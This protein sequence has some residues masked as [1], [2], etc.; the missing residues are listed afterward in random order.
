MDSKQLQTLGLQRPRPATYSEVYDLVNRQLLIGK[1][2]VASLK[3][4]V[5]HSELLKQAQ[6]FTINVSKEKIKLI[7]QL[8]NLRE[9]QLKEFDEIRQSECNDIIGYINELD[10]PGPDFFTLCKKIDAKKCEM[11]ALIEKIMALEAT[12]P[13]EQTLEFYTIKP[14]VQPNLSGTCAEEATIPLDGDVDPDM[15]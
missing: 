7:E 4:Q 11:N 1:M 14:K 15:C 3:L 9:Q 12:L 5:E 6:D 2:S 10:S 13:N 8:N